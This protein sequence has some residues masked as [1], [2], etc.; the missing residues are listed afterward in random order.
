[1]KR[2]PKIALLSG[3]IAL[4]VC[5]SPTTNI[6][7]QNKKAAKPVANTSGKKLADGFT[8]LPSGLEY[9]IV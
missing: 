7:A 3:I 8:R 2:T 4:G 5:S 9:K 1:M 6:F